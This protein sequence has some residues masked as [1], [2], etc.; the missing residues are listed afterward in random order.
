[1]PESPKFLQEKYK[2]SSAREVE[3]AAKRT[4]RRIRLRSA[5]EEQTANQSCQES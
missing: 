4:E 1:M 2:L 3:S 5:S